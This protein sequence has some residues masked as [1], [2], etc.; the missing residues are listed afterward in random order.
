MPSNSLTR[1]KTIRFK[2]GLAAAKQN[3][4]NNELVLFN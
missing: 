2:L 1:E 4:E 3:A